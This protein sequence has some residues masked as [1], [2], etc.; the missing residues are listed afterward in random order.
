[1]MFSEDGHKVDPIFLI[2]EL[3]IIQ[4]EINGKLP[5]DSNLNSIHFWEKAIIVKAFSTNG[6]L[7]FILDI[8]IVA[9]QSYNLLHLY[10]IP[11]NND[12]ILIP[13]NPILILGND[14]F[15]YPHEPCTEIAEDNVICKHLEWQP[16]LHSTDCIAQLL[17]HQ[18][19]HNCTYATASYD[20]NIVQQIKE[21]SWIVIMKQDEVVK[22]ICNNDVQYQRNKGVF[23]ITTDNNCK[24]QIRDRVLMTHKRYI[25]QRET[26]P[27]PEHI[28]SCQC[29]EHHCGMGGKNQWKIAQYEA[30]CLQGGDTVFRPEGVSS[31]EGVDGMVD[32]TLQT[33]DDQEGRP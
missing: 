21:N 11:N 19:P 14:E 1:M 3:N 16:L 2:E 24:V 17:Q 8:P 25:N 22:T 29:A 15:A 6:T 5:F 23:L 18:E 30:D 12:T 32:T 26:I 20:N 7:T 9:E 33:D 28:K 4:N 27:L 13:K 31:E 10:S